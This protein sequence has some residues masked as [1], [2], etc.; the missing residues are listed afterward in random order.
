[1]NKLLK[2]YDCGHQVSRHAQTCPS[3]GRPDPSRHLPPMHLEPFS[4][5]TAKLIR[6][7]IFGIVMAII[8]FWAV[9]E[10]FEEFQIYG[11]N[12]TF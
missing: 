10:A 11:W 9:M 2:C 12:V 8:S 5:P 7:I 3:C 6:Y 1:M 4:S